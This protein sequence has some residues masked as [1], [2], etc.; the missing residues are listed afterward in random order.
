MICRSRSESPLVDSGTHCPDRVSAASVNS[1]ASSTQNTSSGLNI[2]DLSTTFCNSR[3]L[4][5]QSYDRN[6][7]TVRLSIFEKVLPS[8]RPKRAGRSIQATSKYRPSVR[9]A[10]ASGLEIHLDDK[11][12]PLETFRLL[13]PPLDRGW[14]LQPHGRLL[15]WI[16][17][18]R[19]VR[20]PALAT[21]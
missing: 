1:Q 12:D 8:F 4:P 15:E 10:L 18:P 7:S 19:P 21:P 9:A 11:T 14:W 16:A 5:G 17:L 3:T 20:I 13:L 2:T 6:N